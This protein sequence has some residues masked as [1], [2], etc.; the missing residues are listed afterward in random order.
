MYES[1]REM[2]PCGAAASKVGDFSLK[3]RYNWVERTKSGFTW[4]PAKICHLFRPFRWRN[5]NEP[6]AT[7]ISVVEPGHPPLFT[8][9]HPETTRLLSLL[10][11]E[12]IN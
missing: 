6:G 8:R 12:L 3:I 10:V 11:A 5:E 2:I 4:Y 7:V 9:F 1:Q